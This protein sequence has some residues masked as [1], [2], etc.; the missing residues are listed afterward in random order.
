MKSK[1]ASEEDEERTK[2]WKKKRCVVWN[3]R[4]QFDDKVFILPKRH[5]P[6]CAEEHPFSSDI[7]DTTSTAFLSKMPPAS[8]PPYRR[9]WTSKSNGT[10]R[11]NGRTRRVVSIGRNTQRRVEISKKN[12]RSGFKK[13]MSYISVAFSKVNPELCSKH[14]WKFVGTTLIDSADCLHGQI[15][16]APRFGCRGVLSGSLNLN[17]LSVKGSIQQCL[18]KGVRVLFF[19]KH[20]KQTKSRILRIS[21]N[22]DLPRS[23]YKSCFK[24]SSQGSAWFSARFASN[25]SAAVS[26]LVPSVKRKLFHTQWILRVRVCQIVLALWSKL[27]NRKAHPCFLTSTS[28]NEFSKTMHRLETS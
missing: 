18:C 23:T 28:L 8:H 13:I 22:T 5:S 27:S 6:W 26:F 4:R 24:M 20:Q 14:V 15:I 16:F 12:G 25:W 1:R 19:C 17:F 7:F 11:R 9:R 3:I 10:W 2:S 21:E